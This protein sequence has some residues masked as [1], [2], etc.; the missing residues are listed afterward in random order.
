MA[1]TTPTQPTVPISVYSELSTGGYISVSQVKFG[2]LKSNYLNWQAS[3]EFP[4]DRAYGTSPDTVLSVTADH[5]TLK[6]SVHG[7][8]Y[9]YADG[10]AVNC[11]IDLTIVK[12]AQPNSGTYHLKIV[13]FN[14]QVLLDV[15]G[16]LEE[17]SSLVF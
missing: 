9:T 14:G 12:D 6:G 7:A 4:C 11:N 1:T 8:A 16:T 10:H 15:S 3:E 17:V 2:L 5:K 13:A